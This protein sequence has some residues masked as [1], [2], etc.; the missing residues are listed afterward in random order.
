MLEGL[1][2]TGV[3]F[4]FPAGNIIKLVQNGVKLTNST[5]P[6]TLAK[7]ITLTVLDCCAP[8][9]VRI[10][11]HCI[12]VVA[13]IAAS[14]AAPNLATIGSAVHLVTEIYDNC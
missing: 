2:A 1:I 6:L 4:L 11:A 12:G 5:N 10:A 9:P 13:V 7:N 8:P 14:V 3:P